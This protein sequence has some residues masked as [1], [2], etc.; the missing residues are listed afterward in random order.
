MEVAKA[1]LFSEVSR[2]IQEARVKVARTVNSELIM[3]YWSIGNTIKTDILQNN[4][5]EYG[6]QVI[7]GLS[8]QLTEQFGRGWSE[9]QLRHCLRTAEVFTHDEIL[10]ALRTQLTW[11][12]IRSLFSIK[13]ELKRTFYLTM[14]ATEHWDTRTL[15]EKIDSM[16][17]ERS[18]ISR[19]PDE[20]IKAELAKTQD[21]GMLSPDMVFKNSYFLDFVGLKDVYSEK[22][23]EDAILVELQKFLGELGG[24]FAFVARQKQILI[25]GQSYWIDLLFFHR[26]LGRVIAID[27]KLGKFKPE[28]EG[29]MLLYLRWLDRYEK[30]KGEQTP[31]GL[32]LCSEGNTE[33]IEFLMLDGGNVKVAQYY[34]EL[35]D[36]K[37]LEDQMHKAIQAAKLRYQEEK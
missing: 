4:R 7:K 16:I 18:A 1:T 22:D 2:L 37:L 5:A 27:L 29:Q 15:D 8:E 33:H 3:L 30:K 10:Y 14:C 36:R 19:K 13:D 21:S 34:L 12:H 32:I 17:F 24:D 23:L 31:L 11:T 20:L 25:D 28:Y 6:K 35:P 26:S 9:H